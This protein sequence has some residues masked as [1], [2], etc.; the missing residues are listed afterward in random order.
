MATYN[1]TGII[2]RR[3]P[4]GEGDYILT[5]FTKN[6]GKIKAAAK[7]VRKIN[8]RR[9]GHLDLFNIVEFQLRDGY[10]VGYLGEVKSIAIFSQTKNSLRK[11]SHFYY[12]AELIDKLIVDEEK[13]YSLYCRLIEVY[14][15]IEDFTESDRIESDRLLREFEVFLLKNLGYWSESIHGRDYPSNVIHQR[16]FNQNMIREVAEQTFQTIEFMRVSD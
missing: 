13:N 1:D 3:F 16:E 12:L 7:G 4:Y 8:S 11:L 14:S 10:D 15:Q 2:L 6:H 9:G 5:I